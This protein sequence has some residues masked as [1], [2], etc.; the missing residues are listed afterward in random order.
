[1]DDDLGFKDL[2]LSD[3]TLKA[4]AEKGFEEPTAIQRKIIPLFLS[5]TRDIIGQ[6]QTGTGKTAAFGLPIVERVSSKGFLPKALILTPTRELALQVAEEIHSLRGDK[7]LRIQPVYGGQA[8]GAQIRKLKD[9]VDVVVGTPGRVIDHI[10]RK[11]LDLSAIEYLVLDEADEM[12]DMGFAEDVEKI[13]ESVNPARRM[14]LFSATM[15]ARILAIAKRFMPEHERVAVESPAM[16]VGLTE[17]LYFE[18]REED[19][20]E[21]LCRII[22]IEDDFYGLVFCRT[23]I[24]T[25]ELAKHLCLRGYGA[26]ALSGDSTQQQREETLAK[27]RDRRISVVA[28][29]DVAARGIDVENM[30]HVINFSL[31]QDPESYVHRIGRTGRA[32][33]QGM[34]ITFVTPSEYRKLMFIRHTTKADIRKENLPE[35]DAVIEAR[36]KRIV[37]KIESLVD[38]PDAETAASGLPQIRPDMFVMAKTLLEER[39]PERVVAALLSQHYGGAL[40]RSRY[41]EI[42]SAS[43]E[44]SG[45]AKLYVRIGR[46]DG[47]D[48][49]RLIEFLEKEG[50]IERRKLGDIRMFELFSL[51]EVPFREAESV[52]RRLTQ[53]KNRNLARYDRQEGAAG[54]EGHG[55][56]GGRSVQESHGPSAGRFDN[57]DKRDAFAKRDAPTKHYG[58]EKHYGAEKHYPAKKPDFTE[59][60]ETK[61]KLDTNLERDTE[62]KHI[63][64]EKP[65]YTKKPYAKEKPDVPKMSAVKEMPDAPKKPDTKEK[66]EVKKKRAATERY[67]AKGKRPAG[68]AAGKSRAAADKPRKKTKKA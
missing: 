24:L 15:P 43:P 10:E 55:D 36:R 3:L 5:G 30:T 37:E 53:G 4:L 54:S 23:K 11:T 49:M 2:G 14:L 52:L 45:S 1:M 39:E 33:K 31:P 56:Q 26:E 46:K 27:F 7:S 8:I 21:A 66:G 25:A 32:G 22:D 67:V 44:R 65:D 42:R 20:F 16:T 19:K 68:P 63:V 12:L 38:R 40:D 9:G 60:R 57:R 41:R 34:A 6:A 61:E 18:V 47:F 35:I 28:A 50:G 64:K 51:V 17:Q 59:N 62:A 48:K 29:T 13:L 58:P